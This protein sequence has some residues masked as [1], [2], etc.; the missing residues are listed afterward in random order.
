MSLSSNHLI[1]IDGD[2]ILSGLRYSGQI[3][4]YFIDINIYSCSDNPRLHRFS[5]L[6]QK[7]KRKK[8]KKILS[9]FFETTLSAGRRNVVSTDGW[10]RREEKRG[11]NFCL[12]LDRGSNG[13]WKRH[14]AT[15][16]STYR[17]LSSLTK[18]PVCRA[19]MVLDLLPL[20]RQIRTC[21]GFIRSLV[22]DGG[23]TG[24]GSR[25]RRTVGGQKPISHECYARP[26]TNLTCVCIYIYIYTL[27]AIFVK[28]RRDAK[29]ISSRRGDAKLTRRRPGAL[30]CLLAGEY[31]LFIVSLRDR[32][33]WWK[34]SEANASSWWLACGTKAFREIRRVYIE[35][36]IYF[37]SIFLFFLW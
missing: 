15:P 14:A 32:R 13:P 31:Y 24:G 26:Y 6:F 33:W 17:V 4:L 35:S 1:L 36:D 9:N 30:A 7:G 10:K 5:L 25:Q 28:S 3:L 27:L 19:A 2:S 16:F 18:C 11:E 29:R 34:Q 12:P 23:N 20:H 22:N 21:H 8:I 37:S